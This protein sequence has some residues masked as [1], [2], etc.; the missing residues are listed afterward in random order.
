MLA[1]SNGVSL[2]RKSVMTARIS[3]EYPL[4]QNEVMHLDIAHV[5]FSDEVWWKG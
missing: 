3:F 4:Y 1:D 2:P 5:R